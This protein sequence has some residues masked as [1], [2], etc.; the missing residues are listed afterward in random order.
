MENTYGAGG[1]RVVEIP[2]CIPTRQKLPTYLV[3]NL[4]AAQQKTWSLQAP[5]TPKATAWRD[6]CVRNTPAESVCLRAF[7]QCAHVQAAGVEARP[8]ASLIS[9]KQST[10]NA[11]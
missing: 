7:V 10:G 4:L 2:E 6:C 1:I 9:S 11:T 8:A 3:C 5:C